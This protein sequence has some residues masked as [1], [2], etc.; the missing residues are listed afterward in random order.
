MVASR[1]LIPPTKQ[2]LATRISP[3]RYIGMSGFRLVSEAHIHAHPEQ[4]ARAQRKRYRTTKVRGTGL[5]TRPFICIDKPDHPTPLS[6]GVCADLEQ[7]LVN[8]G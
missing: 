6:G 3:T 7:K 4:E 2:T 5:V 1:K 8:I